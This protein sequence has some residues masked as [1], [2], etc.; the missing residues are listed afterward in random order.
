MDRWSNR[1]GGVREE[2]GRRSGKRK[3]EE[4]RSKL[5]L[6]GSK[7]R[8]AK[9]TGAEPSGEMRLW[10]KAHPSQNAENAQAHCD[11]KMIKTHQSQSSFGS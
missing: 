5:F 8:P 7:N 11:V 1:G 2:K 9:A 6:G 3:V 4:R 10:R